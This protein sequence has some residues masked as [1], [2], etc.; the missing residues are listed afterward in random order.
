MSNDLIKSYTFET[1]SSSYVFTGIPQTYRQLYIVWQGRTVSGSGLLQFNSTTTSYY[2]RGV[3]ANNG[4]VST[5][6]GVTNGVYLG[7]TAIDSGYVTGG[8]LWI[9]H[10][11]SDTMKQAV[12]RGAY[13]RNSTTDYYNYFGS[14]SN[15]AT[16]PITSVTF[17][18]TNGANWVIG[19]KVQLYGIE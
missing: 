12:V 3:R 16:A 15:A 6:T 11:T 7:E 14:G 10:Y 17:T 1:A 9:N 5:T 2:N 18:T 8:Q 4:T 19:S 13:I